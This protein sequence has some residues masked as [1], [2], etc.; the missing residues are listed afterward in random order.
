MSEQ[1]VLKINIHG[2][3]YPISCQKG[4]EDRVK[5]SAKL[6]NEV[7]ETIKNPDDKISENRI[8]LM[9]SLILA[10]KNIREDNTDKNDTNLNL[11]DIN[12]VLIWLEKINI[13][14]NKVASLLDES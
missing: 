3:S 4:E 6:L 1:N 10:D 8:L 9:A 2:K 5:Q 13:K 14:F 12:E 7:I 11:I